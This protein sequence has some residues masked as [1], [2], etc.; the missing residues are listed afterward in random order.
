LKQNK[1][2]FHAEKQ[3]TIGEFL[4]PLKPSQSRLPSLSSKHPVIIENNLGKDRE[5][6]SVGLDKFDLL[7]NQPRVEFDV[8]LVSSGAPPHRRHQHHHRLSGYGLAT[9]PIH[10]KWRT[11]EMPRLK[12][13]QTSSEALLA[14]TSNERRKR[15]LY[16][17]K[18]ACEQQHLE[19]SL[20]L[21]RSIEFEARSKETRVRRVNE[22]KREKLMRDDDES[23]RGGMLMGNTNKIVRD[24][25]GSDNF[26]D[27]M[28][29]KEIIRTFYETDNRHIR[30]FKGRGREQ[31]FK[32]EK[33]ECFDK[34]KEKLL[35]DEAKESKAVSVSN[36]T[37]APEK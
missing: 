17:Q 34:L 5:L 11:S 1:K 2:M 10:F 7:T 37:S 15:I 18:C 35:L 36:D 29:Q 23:Y 19:K 31:Y 32:L 20:R 22:M 24:V 27:I 9:T 21:A 4:P 16:E 13:M 26:K 28:L 30:Y 3:L 12:L 6:I 33:N 8:K 25:W 14:E